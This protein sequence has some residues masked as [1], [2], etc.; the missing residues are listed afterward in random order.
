MIR[1]A[2]EADIPKILEMCCKFYP[3]TSY[4]QKSKMQMD[5][6]YVGV[7]THGL[8]ENGLFHVAVDDESEEVVGMIGLIVMPFMFNPKYM[9]A[10]EIIWWVEPEF[11]NKGFGRGLLRSIDVAAKAKGITTV[12]MIDLVES[13]IQAG[14]LYTSEGYQLTEKIWTKVV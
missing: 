5:V 11:W 2:V 12:Q 3:M 7:L 6:E 13:P 1:P 4:W 10:G 14:D 9:T 8:I